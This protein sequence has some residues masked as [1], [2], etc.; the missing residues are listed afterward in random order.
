MSQPIGSRRL[1]DGTTVKLVVNERDELLGVPVCQIVATTEQ[2]DCTI[3]FPF[4][5]KV[6][7]ARENVRAMFD[8]IGQTETFD[9]LQQRVL[10]F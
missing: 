6:A 5:D 2:G 9:E 3:R 10:D 8:G 7:S 1:D 4:P